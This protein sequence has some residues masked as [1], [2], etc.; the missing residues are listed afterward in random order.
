MYNLNVG[1]LFIVI[2]FYLVC[3]ILKKGEEEKS[4]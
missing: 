1:C 4:S 2:V 3:E